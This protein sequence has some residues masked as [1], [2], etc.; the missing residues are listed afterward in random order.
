MQPHLHV[1]FALQDDL[2]EGDIVPPGGPSLLQTGLLRGI[3]VPEGNFLQAR[4]MQPSAIKVKLHVCMCT[5]SG[6]IPPA[7]H[8][9]IQGYLL[10][11]TRIHVGLSW[12]A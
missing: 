3:Q 10:Q 11:G 1:D 4:E 9:P 2:E 6:R 5:A 8:L 12:P 7:G